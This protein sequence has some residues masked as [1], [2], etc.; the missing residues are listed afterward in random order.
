MENDLLEKIN[1]M[2]EKKEEEKNK[3]HNENINTILNTYNKLKKTF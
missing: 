2:A 3:K 1:N